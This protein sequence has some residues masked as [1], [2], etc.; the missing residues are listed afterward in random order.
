MPRARQRLIERPWRPGS[1]RAASRRTGVLDQPS[2][3]ACARGCIPLRRAPF[4]RIWQARSA[5]QWRRSTGLSSVAD[6][7]RD[8]GAMACRVGAA[9]GPMPHAAPAQSARLPNRPSPE[10]T[11]SVVAAPLSNSV[12][13]VAGRG[14]PSPLLCR[15]SIVATAAPFSAAKLLHILPTTPIR[16]FALGRATALLPARRCPSHR[17]LG[18]RQ[19]FVG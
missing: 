9:V 1:L 3:P 5:D 2:R 6:P 14:L 8:A 10:L 17:L 18:P 19:N 16:G 7:S 12:S 15:A 4:V 11:A 13:I